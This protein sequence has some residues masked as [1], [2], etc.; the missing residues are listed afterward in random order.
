MSAPPRVVN[1][2]LTISEINALIRQLQ[3]AQWL[4]QSLRKVKEAK[5]LIHLLEEARK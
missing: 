2:T 4:A 5:A 1:V 3:R